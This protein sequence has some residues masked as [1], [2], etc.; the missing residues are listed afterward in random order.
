MFI[1]MFLFNKRMNKARLYDV[2]MMSHSRFLAVAILCCAQCFVKF[3][4]KEREIEFCRT[5]KIISVGCLHR[6][7]QL[8]GS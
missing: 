3:Q 2:L 6:A 8:V 1:F 4:N 7:W 5:R